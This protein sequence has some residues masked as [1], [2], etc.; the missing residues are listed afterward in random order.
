MLLIHVIS[1][2]VYQDNRIGG[3]VKHAKSSTVV[4]SVAIVGAG[5]QVRKFR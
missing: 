5:F 3:D 1:T 2:Y 4:P